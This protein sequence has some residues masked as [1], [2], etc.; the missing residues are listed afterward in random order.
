MGTDEAN[1]TP[2]DVYRKPWRPTFFTRKQPVHAKQMVQ[3][4]DA[5]AQIDVPL[6]PLI[7][8]IWKRGWTTLNSCHD[9]SG[10]DH[11][12][13]IHFE[14]PAHAILFFEA[15]RNTVPFVVFDRRSNLGV[16]IRFPSV[17]VPAVTVLFPDVPDAI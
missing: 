9:S 13:Y 3:W 14:S 1:A 7:L 5:H 2:D 10:R 4:G 11:L 17:H 16:A 6:A 12:A 15:I 8:Q